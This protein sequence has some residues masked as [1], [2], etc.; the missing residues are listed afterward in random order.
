MNIR[1][2]GALILV[3]GV[4]L[5]FSCVW[6]GD[7]VPL[8]GAETAQ[9]V[10]DWSME[11]IRYSSFAHEDWQTP[12][13][14]WSRGAGDCEDFALL[15]AYV[16]H[17][18]LGLESE[19][20]VGEVTMPSGAILGHAWAVVEGVSYDINNW[21]PDEIFVERVV[22]LGLRQALAYAKSH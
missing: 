20:K 18:E 22:V 8:S 3:L 13:E 19:V 16:C 14:T 2:W 7:T 17:Y 9:E 1:V 6:T 11:N 21:D 5:V 15:I 10:R 12:D 4:A